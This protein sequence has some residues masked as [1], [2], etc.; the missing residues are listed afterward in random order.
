MQLFQS[1]LNYFTGDFSIGTCLHACGIATDLVLK[2]CL[3]ANA[4]FVATP[5]CYGAIK[6]TDVISYPRSNMFTNVP[7]SFEVCAEQ[8]YEQ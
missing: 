2:K 8:Y 6:Q 7:L 4:S 1:N 5:C 3:D